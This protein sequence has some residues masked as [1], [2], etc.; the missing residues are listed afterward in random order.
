MY[1][2]ELQSR[3][4]HLLDLSGQ[5][6]DER[7][8]VRLSTALTEGV[9]IMKKLVTAVVLFL[10]LI[11]ASPNSLQPKRHSLDAVSD[12]HRAD[13]LRDAHLMVALGD[14]S[15]W[16]FHSCPARAE[17]SCIAVTRIA[18][19]EQTVF[20]AADFLPNMPGGTIPIGAG[21]QIY[22]VAN[23]NGGGVAV[24][25][26]WNDGRDSHN[27]V[28]FAS[29]KNDRYSIDRVVEFPTVRAIVPGPRGTVLAI[30]S[31]SSLAGG[32]P[33]LTLVD[34][35]GHTLGQWFEGDRSR[36]AVRAAQGAND[37]RL[38]QVAP[39]RFALFNP[40]DMTLRVFDL[41]ENAS[42][43]MHSTAVINDD[44]A[45]QTIRDVHTSP[46]GATAI[47]GVGKIDGEYRTSVNLYSSTGALTG[48]WFSDS[49]W[50]N[51]DHRGQVFK[52]IIVRDDVRTE[53]VEFAELQ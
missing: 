33:Q 45:G 50:H 42:L 46:N 14:G 20:L 43:T 29:P 19:G 6:R 36:S 24:S 53:T 5:E 47:V 18:K 16:A 35:N 1:R 37:L 7:P 41:S 52:G 44:L 31:D 39:G 17:K 34:S 51:V 22:S 25:L 32:G 26:G 28:V 2:I 38:E 10:T 27:A 4:D 23:L 13:L 8:S 12:D 3:D 30:T 40:S 11:A 48:R 49:P 9:K 15:E 21:G